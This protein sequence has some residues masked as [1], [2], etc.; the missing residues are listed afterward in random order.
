LDQNAY[1]KKKYAF[2]FDTKNIDAEKLNIQ[3]EEAADFM[4]FMAGALKNGVGSEDV[5]VMAAVE[6]HVN[7][8]NH[9][10]P[11]D[12]N[13]FVNQCRFFLTDDFHRNMMEGQQIG[14]SYY[15][16]IAAENYAQR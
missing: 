11:L 6:S 5:K 12:A 7:F 4:S 3:A 1:L 16:C 14:L 9:I 2:E 10:R 15:I 13:G 8:L